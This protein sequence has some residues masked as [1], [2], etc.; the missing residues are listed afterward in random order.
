MKRHRFARTSSDKRLKTPWASLSLGA[1]RFLNDLLT[2]PTYHGGLQT[3]ATQNEL[4]RLGLIEVSYGYKMAEGGVPRDFV[5]LTEKG[6]RYDKDP[7]VLAWRE[8]P[9]GW[10]ATHGTSKLVAEVKELLK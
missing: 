7:D 8:D 9:L 6:K 2:V 1:Q 5:K 3:N 4:Q 10:T